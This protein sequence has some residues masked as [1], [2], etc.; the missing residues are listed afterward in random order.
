MRNTYNVLLWDLKQAPVP[1]TAN[2]L[3]DPDSD[4]TCNQIYKY[5][6]IYIY[7]YI[8]SLEMII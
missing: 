3:P 4:D 5:I 7:V 8:D 6:Y 2:I 1:C